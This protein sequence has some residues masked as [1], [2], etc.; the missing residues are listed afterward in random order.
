MTEATRTALEDIAKNYSY[1]A[2]HQFEAELGWESWMEEYMEGDDH[3][4]PLEDSESKAIQEDL[5][6]IFFEAHEEEILEYYQEMPT[7]GTTIRR[8]FKSHRGR[9]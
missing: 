1:D 9:I 6:D 3:D 2:F 4:R 5:L 7:A 8:I